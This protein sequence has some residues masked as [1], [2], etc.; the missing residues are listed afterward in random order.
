MVIPG[1]P[2]R[3]RPSGA[4]IIV[5]C[6]GALPMQE[7]YPELEESDEAR[8]GTAAHWVFHQ[9][10]EGV[11]VEEGTKASN[12]VEVTDE[13]L[14]GADMF[15]D[16]VDSIVA[17][18]QPDEYMFAFEQ[19][20]DCS[21]IHEDNAGTPDNWIF[22]PSRMTL[23]INDYKFGYG[24]VDVK[25]N[26]QIIDYMA[27]LVKLLKLDQ[28][29]D[30]QVTIDMGVIQP[31]YYHREGHVRRW[32]VT[33]A[34]LRAH[35]NKM[36]NSFAEATGD[37]PRLISGPHCLHCTARHACPAIDLSAAAAFSY[38]QRAQPLELDDQA[39]GV[40]LIFIEEAMDR[41]TA[42]Y[43]GLKADAEARISQGR[44]IAHWGHAPKFGRKTWNRP[45]EE[46]LMLGDLLGYN[47]RKKEAPITVAQALKLKNVDESVILEYCETPR[48][49]YELVRI[50][51]TLAFK[52]FKKVN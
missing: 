16:E 41:I 6:P 31:R 1:Q 21:H 18:L 10:A 47:L 46:V 23:Y 2:A 7:L 8:E 30:T 5:P 36:I 17:G 32:V 11:L 33:L 9:K 22:V 48:R 35:V 43:K 38:V 26:W 20:V 45:P 27:G 50:E 29:P 49:G 42:R 28:V 37:T 40:E 24:F 4:P 34:E 25:D 52:A 12:G 14:D 39:L 44:R 13:M 19:W 51:E 15:L 3:I